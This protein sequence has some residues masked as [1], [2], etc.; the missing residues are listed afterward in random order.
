VMEVLEMW[1]N[2]ADEDFLQEMWPTVKNALYWQIK[3]AS[4]IG[5]PLHL[6]CTYDIIDFDQYNSTT[7]NSFLHLAMMRA[8]LELA[9]HVGDTQ[10][11]ADVSASFTRAQS[12]LNALLWNSTYS[13][14]RAYT[15]GEAIMAD[16]LY[17]QMVAHHHGLGWL[18]PEAQINS[19]LAAELKYNGNPYGLTV[20]TGRSTPPPQAEGE[21]EVGAGGAAATT[22]RA[23]QAAGGMALWKER[24]GVDTRDDT[25][26][27]GAGP[28]W[29]Y[30]AIALGAQFTGGDLTAA[31]EPARRSL[32]NWRSRLNDLWN[33]AGLT[34][35]GD[36]GDDTAN[37]QPWITSHYGFMLTVRGR[38]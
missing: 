11:A 38:G 6:V 33:I 35:T 16:C 10:T 24:L 5:L 26:W 31:L 27:M 36:W 18:M 20:V 1:R 8:G 32:E 25:C 12:A 9:Q 30:V 3:V 21:A 7:F 2:T 4:A 19:H 34:S 28:D 17:G 14:F 23:R 15:G 22:L 13:Y 29:S 37:G